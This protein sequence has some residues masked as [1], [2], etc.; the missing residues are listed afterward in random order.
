MLGDYKCGDC[1]CQSGDC[2]H[3]DDNLINANVVIIAW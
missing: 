1:N 3:G 2:K